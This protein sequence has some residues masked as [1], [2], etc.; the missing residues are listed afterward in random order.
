MF[1]Y[2]EV[3][4]TFWLSENWDSNVNVCDQ[5]ANSLME[6]EERFEDFILK[7]RLQLR[8]AR[9]TTIK[10]AFQ[11]GQSKENLVCYFLHGEVLF[12]SKYIFI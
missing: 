8:A 7:L 9:G 12:L 2:C 1:Q 11:Q 6:L 4:Q 10:V 3:W 5:I